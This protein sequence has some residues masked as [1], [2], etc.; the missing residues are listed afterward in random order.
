MEAVMLALSARQKV[1]DAVARRAWAVVFWV[2]AVLSW[3]WRVCWSLVRR[4]EGAAS[5]MGMSIFIG[6]GGWD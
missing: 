5:G 6:M 1:A 4:G 2:R 3:F